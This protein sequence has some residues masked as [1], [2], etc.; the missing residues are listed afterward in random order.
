MKPSPRGLTGLQ[1]ASASVM[2]ILV[3]ITFLLTN[4]QAVLWQSSQWLV[5]TVLPA[6][7]VDLTN[8]ERGEIAEKPLVRSATLDAAAKLKAEDMAKNEYFAHYSPTNVSPWHWFDEAGYVYAY[9]GENLA[10]HFTDSTEVVDAWMNSPAHR[11]NIVN[12]LY[13]EIGV[14]T[15]KGKYE[16]YDTVYVVQLFG[17]PAVPPVATTPVVVPP[18]T[19]VE[20]EPVPE[21]D[22]LAVEAVDLTQTESASSTLPQPQNEVLAETFVA[23]SIEPENIPATPTPE[24]MPEIEQPKDVVVL[25]LPALATSSGLTVATV[26]NT[27][28]NHAGATMA[29]LATQPNVLLQTVYMFL[30]SLVVLMLSVSMVL[31]IRRVHYV[32]VA[33]SCLLLVGMGALWYLHS[34]LTLGAVVV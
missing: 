14:G 32:Q 2:S 18:A 25:N 4:I 9:A 17:T 23:R 11:A 19:L 27:Q 34:I 26:T 16:G 3:I 5:G 22:L 13:T 21:V 12:G 7:V 8:K 15:A 31:E 6:V 24:Q 10:I 28:Q 1:K 29:S 20:A 30:G 33:Y